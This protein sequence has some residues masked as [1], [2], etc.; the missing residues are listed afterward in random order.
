MGYRFGVPDE[1]E[2][3]FIRVF[4]GTGK[5]V[6]TLRPHNNAQAELFSRILVQTELS[7]FST[8][9]NV[10]L[11]AICR[12]RT[13][14][15]TWDVKNERYTGPIKT[16]D[17]YDVLWIEW[18]DGVAYRLASGTADKNNWEELELEHISLILG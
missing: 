9:K 12:T 5:R 14:K 7:N 1:Q 11:V 3:I 6:G 8:G 15:K 13:H 10:E 4:I 17:E 2:E 16:S 18:K